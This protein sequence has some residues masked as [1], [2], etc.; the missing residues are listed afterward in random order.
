[1]TLR[2]LIAPGNDIADAKREIRCWRAM[3]GDPPHLFAMGK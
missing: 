2:I 3:P 1:M